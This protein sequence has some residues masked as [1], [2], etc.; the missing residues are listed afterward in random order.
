LNTPNHH[1]S[2]NNLIADPAAFPPPTGE[3]GE[4]R[5]VLVVDDEPVIR[6]L[7]AQ[8]LSQEGFKVL[9]AGGPTEALRLATTATIHLLLTDFSMPEGDGL[10]LTRRFRTV[11]PR[12]PVLIVSGSLPAI[13]RNHL[14]L[15]GMLEK[16]FVVDELVR[17]VRLLLNE[18]SPLPLRKPSANCVDHQSTP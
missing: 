7:L 6:S 14:D 18:V 3:T 13:D 1:Y 11:H 17:K 2:S 15:F 8:I 10:E 12:A 5:T 4:A 16:P 9:Q